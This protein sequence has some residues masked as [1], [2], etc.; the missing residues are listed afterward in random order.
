VNQGVT[1]FNNWHGGIEFVQFDIL[2]TDSQNRVCSDLFSQILSNPSYVGEKHPIIKP[3]LSLVE[4][5]KESEEIIKK[6]FKNNL[7]Q[8]EIDLIKK[9]TK[10]LMTKLRIIKS[11][12]D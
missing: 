1:V 5:K 3:N 11:G 7:N 6:N 9:E 12:F 8:D 2:I 4:D 10:T